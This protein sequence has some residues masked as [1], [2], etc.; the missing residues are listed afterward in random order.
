M[1]YD[2]YVAICL[3]LYYNQIMNWKTCRNV[4]IIMWS[5]NFF[6]S[7]VP[8]VSRP[9]VFCRANKLD[10]FV[11]EI[12]AVLELVC[13]HL[14]YYKLT[15]FVVSLFTLAL[16]LVFIVGSYILIISSLLKIRSTDGRSKAFST[17]ASHLTVVSMFFGTSISMYMGQKKGFST[18]LKYISIIYGVITPVLNPLIYSLRN[19]DVKEAFQKILTKRS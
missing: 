19:N 9:M 5:G 2:R 16:P 4:M 8:I 7:V 3:P 11:C 15:I 6:L 12:L 10:H 14:S 1:A 17:C 18:N 13:R